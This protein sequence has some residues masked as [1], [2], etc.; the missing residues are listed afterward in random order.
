[1][2]FYVLS[3][4]PFMG[5]CGGVIKGENMNMKRYMHFYNYNYIT[6]HYNHFSEKSLQKRV[7][8]AKKALSFI[9]ENEMK[10]TQISLLCYVHKKAKCETHS[11]S[12]SEFV[13]HFILVQPGSSIH[14]LVL[15]WP[16]T[17]TNV[18]SHG[19]HGPVPFPVQNFYSNLDLDKVWHG[20][21][22]HYNYKQKKTV[23][24]IWRWERELRIK[25]TETEPCSCSLFMT[26]IVKILSEI[27]SIAY[28]PTA[29]PAPL[30][31]ASALV[32]VLPNWILNVI[33]VSCYAGW[34]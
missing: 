15:S 27:T 28:L 32:L 5:K 33:I 23:S 16:M 26:L 18:K 4:Y 29:L 31:I 3:F 22:L 20:K 7:P 17:N 11:H 25:A 9:D 1:M 8:W 19:M 10:T 34:S 24:L 21:L 2:H 12:E 13:L 14:F 6:L 30:A